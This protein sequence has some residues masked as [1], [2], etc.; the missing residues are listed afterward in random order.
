MKRKIKIKVKTFFGLRKTYE[1]E[2]PI[3]SN[4]TNV[5]AELSKLIGP[6]IMENLSNQKFYYPIVVPK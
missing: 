2:L 4:L 1:I 6:D 3:K 5:S